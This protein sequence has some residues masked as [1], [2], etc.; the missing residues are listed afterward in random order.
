MELCATGLCE[1]G[2]RAEET[3]RVGSDFVSEEPQGL[4]CGSSGSII[5]LFSV[6]TDPT[7]DTVSENWLSAKSLEVAPLCARLSGCAGCKYFASTKVSGA[8]VTG[9][10]FERLRNMDPKRLGSFSESGLTETGLDFIAVGEG[11]SVDHVL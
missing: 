6:L 1:N 4:Y 2:L 8:F 11:G 10:I 5:E 3:R 9:S 7:V